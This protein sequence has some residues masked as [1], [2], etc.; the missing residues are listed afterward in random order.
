MIGDNEHLRDLNKFLL[1]KQRSSV[2]HPVAEDLVAECLAI[3]LQDAQEMTLSEQ[4]DHL[5]QQINALLALLGHAVALKSAV[6]FLK[7]RGGMIYSH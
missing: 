5:R 4:T 3:L 6:H 1:R 2:V 7:H